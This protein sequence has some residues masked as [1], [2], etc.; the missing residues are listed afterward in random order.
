VEEAAD[1]LKLQQTVVEERP[2]EI[3]EE[4]IVEEAVVIRKKPKKPFEPSVEDLEETEFS[5]SF[6]KPH[7]INEGVEEA[8]TVLKKRPVKPTTLDE[9]AAELSIKR[10]EEEYEEGDDVEEFVVSQPR[11]PKPLQITEED[12]E[13]YTVKKLKRRK[14][15]DIPE[16][17]DVENV[18]FRARSTKTKEDVDQEFNIALDSYAEEEISMSG[19]IKLKKPI[20]KTFSEAADEAKIRIIQDYDDGEEPIIEEIRDD[21]DTIDE[22]EEPEEYFVEEL[23][24]DEV[25]FKLK[26][27]KQPKPAYSVQDEEEEQF[28]IGIRHPKRDSVTY[29]EDSLTFKKKRKVVQQL[30]NEGKSFFVSNNGNLHTNQNA[31]LLQK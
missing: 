20:K 25:D 10:Q 22:V 30:F 8:A 26:P 9:A 1:E 15:V 12:E 24:P 14:Q 5:L 3:E 6:K 17:A 4:E 23:P 13:A 21:E 28:L 18:T 16:Y 2:V 27:R 29:D 19:K 31:L 11:K 7:T